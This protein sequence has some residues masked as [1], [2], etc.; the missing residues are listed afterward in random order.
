M[1]DIRELPALFWQGLSQQ[2]MM[3][4]I[5]RDGLLT[6]AQTLRAWQMAGG[7][8]PPRGRVQVVLPE[9]D[10]ESLIATLNRH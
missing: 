9:V 2:E 5:K 1:S 8:V 7:G 6:R 4:I 10:V 3:G